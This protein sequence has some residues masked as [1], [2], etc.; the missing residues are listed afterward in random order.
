VVNDLGSLWTA[1]ETL[2]GR[3]LDP[4]DPTLVAALRNG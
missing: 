2:A 3:P 1:A 4:L